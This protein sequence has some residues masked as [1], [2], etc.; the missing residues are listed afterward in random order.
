MTTATSYSDRNELLDAWRGARRTIAL[1]A[2]DQKKQALADWVEAHQVCLA[3][4]ELIA[5]G[6]TSKILSERCPDLSICAMKS[7]PLGGDQQVGA[8]IATGNVHMLVFFTDPLSPHPHDVDV[9]ALSRLADPLARAIE[10][11][12]QEI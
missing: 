10:P 2:H 9:K 6:T 1:I 4:H 5:T 8:M 11:L 12:L 3:G 7:G